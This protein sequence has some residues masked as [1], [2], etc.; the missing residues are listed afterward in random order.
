MLQAFE[1]V[2]TLTGLEFLDV[3]GAKFYLFWGIYL[4]HYTVLMGERGVTVDIAYLQKMTT[5]AQ[6]QC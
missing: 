4:G 5:G 6:A 2:N 1:M 3:N